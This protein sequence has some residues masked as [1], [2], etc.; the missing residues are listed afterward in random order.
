M[1]LH[2]VIA[3]LAALGGGVA[4]SAATYVTL[5]VDPASAAT[6]PAE[7]APKMRSLGYFIRHNEERDDKV[8]FCENNPG[9][10]M[11]D[12]ECENARRASVELKYASKSQLLSRYPE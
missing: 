11:L 6:S 4:G 2:I 10:K 7:I 12:P 5:H 8:A 1:K 9:V 3:V